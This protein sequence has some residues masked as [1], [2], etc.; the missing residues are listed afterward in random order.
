MARLGGTAQ[1]PNPRVQTHNWLMLRRRQT[2]T[3]NGPKP[4]NPPGKAG[5]QAR[6]PARD[7]RALHSLYLVE[8]LTRGREGSKCLRKADGQLES[9]TG[10]PKGLGLDPERTWTSAAPAT[11]DTVLHDRPRAGHPYAVRAGPRRGPG[12]TSDPR[13]DGGAASR[14]KAGCPIHEPAPAPAGRDGPPHP[15]RPANRRR[16]SAPG[17]PTAVPAQ[18]TRAGGGE[19]RA[20]GRACEPLRGSRGRPRA[21][22]TGRGA[23]QPWPI[24]APGEGSR[25]DLA[26]SPWKVPRWFDPPPRV[27]C[28]VPAP[29]G[30]ISGGAA[31]ISPHHHQ[32]PPHPGPRSVGPD[33]VWTRKE[34]GAIW[35]GLSK[36]ETPSQSMGYS[37]R[38]LIRFP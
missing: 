14:D 3:Q 28:L 5:E 33:R 20:A 11:A 10:S 24:A 26:L 4:T 7:S 34:L 23:P 15:E 19:V 32:V 17:R 2:L 38:W 12:D 31:R 21:R 35:V 36:D 30:C 1:A 37:G 18:P 6:T 25:A 29:A 9:P 16:R 22:G 27:R 8:G 13:Q